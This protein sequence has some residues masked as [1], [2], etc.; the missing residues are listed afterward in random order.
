MSYTFCHF[1]Y[2]NLN[3]SAQFRLEDHHQLREL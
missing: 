3:P 1:I 2:A